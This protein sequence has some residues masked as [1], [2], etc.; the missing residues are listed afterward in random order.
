MKK[1]SVCII[2]LI[3]SIALL[4]CD[5]AQEEA[6]VSHISTIPFSEAKELHIS[7][8]VAGQRFVLLSTDE[9][10]LFQRVDKI[11]AK[12]DQFYLFDHL[13]N[14]G[15]LVF[16]ADGNFIRK[17]GEYGEGPQQLKDISDFQ[18]D[19]TGEVQLLDKVNKSI[20]IYSPEGSWKEK[21]AVPLNAAGFVELGSNWFFSV[22]YDHQSEN[23]VRNQVLGVFDSKMELDSLYFDYPEGATNANLYYHAGLLAKSKDGLLYHRPPNDTI[24]VFSDDGKLTDRLVI[25]F[26]QNQLPEEA[27]YDFGKVREYKQQD[28]SFRYLQT[29]ALP[30]GRYVFGTIASTKNEIWTYIYT[31][32][33]KELY[34]FKVDLGKLHMKDLILPSANMDDRAVVSMIDPMTFSQD[35]A[36]EAYPEEVR[37][38]LENEGSVL[39][40]HQLKP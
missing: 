22:N 28:A 40:I 11:I 17:I 9:E 21:V 4:G 7:D 10:A 26:G 33:T 16:G 35:A 25:D 23:L 18:V 39:L 6:G 31:T 15:V 30:V 19:K 24:S 14:S 36:S 5:P 32:D 1:A 29:P 12:N 34:S 38:H 27:V 37:N 3:S 20:V 13:G 8:F 2:W